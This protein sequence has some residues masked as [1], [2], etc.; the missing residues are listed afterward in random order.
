MISNKKGILIA[1][2]GLC[3]IGSVT[4][5]YI[6]GNPKRPYD[7][8]GVKFC[9]QTAN[10]KDK[11]IAQ[12]KLDR[13][14]CDY[15]R[16]I[17][18]EVWEQ[19]QFEAPKPLPEPN[20]PN[21]A[22]VTRL[23]SKSSD[24]E[25]YSLLLSPILAFTGYLLWAKKSEDDENKLH[26][27]LES[28]KTSI[29][30]ST[31]E[32]RNVRDIRIGDLNQRADALRIQKKHIS[33]EALQDKHQKR[34]EINEK[35]HESTL[36]EMQMTDS[37]FEKSIAENLRDAAKAD[38][39]REKI[40]GNKKSDSQT[41]TE[42]SNK[43]LKDDLTDALK[44]HEDGWLWKILDNQKPIWVLG[45]AGSGKSTLA[46]SLVMMRQWLFDMP[47]YQLVD[48]HAG[49]NLKKSWKH[50]NPALVAQ[51]EE[52][53]AEAFDSARSRWSDRINN[54]S[55]KSPQQLLVDEFTNYSDSDITKE[56]A[57]RF[58]KSSLSDPRKAEERLVCIAHFF[59]NTATGGSDGTSKGRDRGTIRI[60]RKTANGK[61]PLK[62]V[63]INGLNDSNGEPIEDLK[64]TIPD[65]LNPDLINNHFSNFPI[66]F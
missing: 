61:T 34:T 4:S 16:K 59:T 49:D 51:S 24:L 33:L 15:E 23:I 47:L 3:V 19:A 58:V 40:L 62:N 18:K 32:S 2:S 38:K 36:K 53:I 45:E 17:L 42:S 27:A 7:V 41:P 55:D 46:A 9:P 64:G 37:G 11:V 65:W 66:E 22:F 1:L 25:P 50:L 39:E 31:T 10:L 5:A 8:I 52:E 20:T 14:Y 30:V 35:L 12:E 43:K 54:Q 48:A 28:Y 26:L 63:T 13:T 21:S 6:F 44:N 29:R 56:P 60:D 57:R